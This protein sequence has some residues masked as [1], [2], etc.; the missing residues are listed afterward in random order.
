MPRGKKDPNKPKGKKGAYIFFLEDRRAQHGDEKIDFPAFSKETSKKWKELTPKDKEKYDKLAL[1]DK[2]RYEEEMADY[3][4]PSSEDEE[5]GAKKRKRKTKEKDPNQPK[6]NMSSYFH[7]CGERR[8]EAK[9]ENPG[10]SVGDIAKVMSAIWRELTDTEKGKY[11]ELARKD[12]ERYLKAMEEYN[13]KPSK[14]G[15]VDE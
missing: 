11:E 13:G 9:E 8:A 4:P 1:K 3:S 6:R 5:E 14:K 15:R 12:K 10:A 7:F 2:K